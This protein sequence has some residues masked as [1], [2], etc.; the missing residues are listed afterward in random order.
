MRAKLEIEE[1][2]AFHHRVE[3]EAE[4]EEKLIEVCERI[5]NVRMDFFDDVL[6]ELER[7]DGVKIIEVCQDESGDCDEVGI[8]D[9]NEQRD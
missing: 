7:A 2:I 4:N 1:I 6:L 9:W 3:V 5:G 8:V